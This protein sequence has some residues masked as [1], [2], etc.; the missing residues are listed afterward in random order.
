MNIF[1]NENRDKFVEKTKGK[2]DFITRFLEPVA[3]QGQRQH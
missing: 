2:L 1:S 3:M